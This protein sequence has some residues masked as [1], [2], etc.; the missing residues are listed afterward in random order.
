MDTVSDIIK[1][2][3]IF[4]FASE[5]NSTTEESRKLAIK[6]IIQ[7]SVTQKTAL[8]EF[9]LN[10]E[11]L[12]KLQYKKQFYR[13]KSFQREDRIKKYTERMFKDVTYSLANQIIELLNTG[14][15]K[16]KDIEY[17][18][19][20]CEIVTINTISVKDGYVVK[21]KATTSAKTKK[22]SNTVSD[23][24]DAETVTSDSTN[25]TK[26]SKS[27]TKPKAKS[28]KPKAKSVKPKAKSVKPKEESVKPKEE[29]VKP[30]EES[31]KPKEE[32][33]K[34]KEESV[35]PKAKSVKPKDESV[36]PKEESVKP[37]EETVKPK[38]EPIK[39]KTERTI[40]AKKQNDD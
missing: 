35:K 31:V 13:L 36:K 24:S 16:N 15:L 1:D 6:A 4:R 14:K 7:K 39:K 37:K 17:D 5:L 38:E 2:N 22:E 34:P 20:K 21:K 18:I 25:S 8:E 40:R 19:D 33:V 11:K 12:D 30:K 27:E 32:S 10:L 23:D 26:S 3:K 29:S 28:V 9:N